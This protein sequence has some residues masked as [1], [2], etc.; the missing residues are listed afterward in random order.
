MHNQPTGDDLAASDK[1]M[2]CLILNLMAREEQQPWS[3]DEIARVLSDTS[4]LAIQDALTYLRS[5][6]LINQAGE[7]FFASRATA[8]L[9]Y[10]GMI[11]L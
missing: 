7:L 3:V 10:L 4:T 1:D 8:H 2:Q 5:T 11:T 6:G 9:S